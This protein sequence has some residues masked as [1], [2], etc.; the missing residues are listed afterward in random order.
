[1]GRQARRR[2]KRKGEFVC[3]CTAYDFPHRQFGGNCDGSQWVE[4]YRSDGPTPDCRAC[5]LHQQGYC[6]VEQ[7]QESPIECPALVE[8]VMY[9]EITL[10]VK[11]RRK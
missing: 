2:R 11:W 5:H 1:M 4:E 10:P 8:H 6:E 9:Y 7:G 3:E